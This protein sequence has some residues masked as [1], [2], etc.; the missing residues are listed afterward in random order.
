M[1]DKELVDKALSQYKKRKE[2]VEAINKEISKLVNDT[3]SDVE[4]REK[5]FLSNRS[6]RNNFRDIR[7][8]TLKDEYLKKSYDKYLDDGIISNGEALNIIESQKKLRADIAKSLEAA[9]E[10]E[11]ATKLKFNKALAEYVDVYLKN[12]VTVTKGLRPKS[13]FKARKLRSLVATLELDD[14][15]EINVN[16]DITADGHPVQRIL[17]LIKPI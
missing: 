4:S 12:L 2:Q 16:E 1:V 15:S 10:E 9:I 8:N 5:S 17:N 11:K 3:T 14:V 6:Q 13:F 7:S